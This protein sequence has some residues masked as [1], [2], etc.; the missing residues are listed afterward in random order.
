M[1][2]SEQENEIV[3][4]DGCGASVHEGRCPICFTV[5]KYVLHAYDKVC[6]IPEAGFSLGR[7]SR[8]VRN[9]FHFLKSD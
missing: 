8:V 5:K 3:E 2:D 6:H 9:P 1:Y 7:P 4:C